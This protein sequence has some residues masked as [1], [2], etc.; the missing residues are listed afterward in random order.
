MKL[1]ALSLLTLLSINIDANNCSLKVQDDFAE[2]YS[3][4]YASKYDAAE[5]ILLNVEK[6]LTNPKSVCQA[7]K[8]VR[9]MY[10]LSDLYSKQN[11]IKQSEEVIVRAEGTMNLHGMGQSPLMRYLLLSRGLLFLLIGD[12]NDAK[13]KLLEAKEFFEKENNCNNN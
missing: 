7:E 1:F 11:M 8:Y 9:A 13:Q 12:I 6:K 2:Y 4:Y 5:S 10:L 3:L